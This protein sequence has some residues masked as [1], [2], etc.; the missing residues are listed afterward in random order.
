MTPTSALPSRSAP[1]LRGLPR[2]LVV[3]ASFPLSGLLAWVALGP[4]TSPGLAL[5]GGLI[6][7]LAIGA[8][9]A[10]ALRVP[11]ASWSLLSG[12]GLATG[13]LL[14][15][16]LTDAMDAGA[17]V[18]GLA[19]AALAGLGVA[20]AQSFLRPPLPRR[21]WITLTLGAWIVAWGVSLAVAIDTSQGFSV[22]G[23][24]GALAFT[25]IVA[26]TTILVARRRTPA[27]AA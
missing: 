9:E 15:R 26:L 10:W 2:W 22:F 21:A 4:I 8:T 12:L 7:G 23:A 20:V 13:S 3:L 18:E 6:V 27:V 11:I 24:S 14:G 1:I 25:A 5:A 19:T 16:L 17:V